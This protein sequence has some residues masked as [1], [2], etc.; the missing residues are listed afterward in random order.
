M[1]LSDT[2]PIFEGPIVFLINGS[3]LGITLLILFFFATV[4]MILRNEQNK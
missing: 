1:I 2:L 3:G 4:A